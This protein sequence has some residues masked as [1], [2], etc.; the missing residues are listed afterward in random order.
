MASLLAELFHCF[1]LTFIVHLFCWFFPHRLTSTPVPITVTIE[2][3]VAIAR[4][5]GQALERADL[6]S[7]IQNSNKECSW[8]H[9][10][11]SVWLLR[12]A[13]LNQRLL[14]A[15]WIRKLNNDFVICFTILSNFWRRPNFFFPLV[16]LADSEL[17]SNWSRP[18]RKLVSNWSQTGHEL[19]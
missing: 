10:F 3:I 19:V 15:H 12:L 13:N 7:M 14:N 5:R 16:V 11:K 8:K 6:R 18:G 2:Q 9:K 17:V 1:S 4:D